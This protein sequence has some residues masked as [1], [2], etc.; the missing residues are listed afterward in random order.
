[1]NQQRMQALESGDSMD[2][3]GND[4]PRCPHCGQCASVIDNERWKLYEEGEHEVTC[5]YCG[6]DFAVS[7]RVSYSFS[8]DDQDDGLNELLDGCGQFWRAI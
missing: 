2:F 3:W 1:M 7:T 6:L 5:P 4:E 8:T